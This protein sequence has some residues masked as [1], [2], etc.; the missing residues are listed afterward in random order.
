MM[1]WR[2]HAASVSLAAG[3]DL[4]QSHLTRGPGGE[5]ELHSEWALAVT[6]PAVARAVLAEISS[7]ARQIAPLGAAIALAPGSR[8]TPE[9]RR[10]LNA[11]S[12]WLWVLNA[13]IDAAQRHEPVR[14]SELELLRA[15][16]AAAPPPRRLPTRAEPVAG[17][18]R[19]VITSAERARHAAWVS[20]RQPASSLELTVNSLRRVAATSTVTSHHCEI[21]L[22]T[23]ATYVAGHS[24]A[25]HATEL[26]QAADAARHTR[27][28]WLR[29]AHA[30]DRVTTDTRL[31]LSPE[32]AES[33]DLALWTGRLAYTD[34]AWTLSSGPAH[35]PGRPTAWCPGQM[36]SRSPSPPSTTP[37]TP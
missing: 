26:L 37:A 7:L 34:P 16:P 33:A 27:E 19:G 30:L 36:T 9:A 20:G 10:N 4:L 22:R 2:L 28:S 17:L 31:H 1:A 11:A 12:Q 25:D 8:G 6:S 18:C 29:V 15:I 14:E 3:R 23:L 13:S 24:Q 35:R 21:L 5:R 32:A